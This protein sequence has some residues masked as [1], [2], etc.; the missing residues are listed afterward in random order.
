MLTRHVWVYLN[1]AYMYSYFIE[2]QNHQGWK[3][4]PRSSRPTVHLP[5]ISPI[6]PCPSV[7]HLNVSWAQEH[8]RQAV[9]QDVLSLADSCLSPFFTVLLL[10][11]PCIYL[12]LRKS[13]LLH[14]SVV[15]KHEETALNLCHALMKDINKD[16]PQKWKPA[17]KV[18]DFF[19]ETMM[20]L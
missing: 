14:P 18:F 2:S 1:S 11:I 16:C 3:R 12:V 8:S 20:I 10:Y 13:L 19:V 9:H 5:T 6:K 7:Q 17:K 4:P 15:V